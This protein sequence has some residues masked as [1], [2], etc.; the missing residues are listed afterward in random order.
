MRS[1]LETRGEAGSL[2]DR[3]R[4]S[5]EADRARD[6]YKAR[7]GINFTDL[8]A[9]QVKGQGRAK[10]INNRVRRRPSATSR[11]GA[12]GANQGLVNSCTS[13]TLQRSN[14]EHVR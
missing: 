1:S 2:I 10:I 5:R 11:E 14:K 12:E 8:D 4:V 6:Y 13:P 7:G 9:A 3:W